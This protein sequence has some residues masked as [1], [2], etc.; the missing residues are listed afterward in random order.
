MNIGHTVAVA[1]EFDMVVDAY[2]GA[3]VLSVGIGL[4]SQRM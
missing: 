4:L 1:I 2:R 3:L